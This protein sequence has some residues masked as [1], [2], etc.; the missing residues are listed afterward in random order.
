[1]CE[2]EIMKEEERKS[3]E[4]IVKECILFVCKF[5]EK[6]MLLILFFDTLYDTDER[7]T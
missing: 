6:K 2:R 5:M 7:E 3:I 1:M 4:K